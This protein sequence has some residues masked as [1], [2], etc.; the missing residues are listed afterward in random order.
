ME[1]ADP[2]K[3][4]VPIY[5]ITQSHIREGHNLIFIAVRISDLTGT[6]DYLFHKQT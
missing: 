4:L 2:S 6:D 3:T 5:Q 1:A